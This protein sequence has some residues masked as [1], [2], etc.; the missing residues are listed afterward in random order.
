MNVAQQGRRKIQTAR[1]Q[2]YGRLPASR[3]FRDTLID[4]PLDALELNAGNDGADVDGFVERRTDSQSV[5]AVLNLADQ[6]FCDALLH[7]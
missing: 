2:G 7:Q 6:F 1:R 5:H 4:Q 3:A